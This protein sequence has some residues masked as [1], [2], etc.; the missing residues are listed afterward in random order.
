MAPRLTGQ[1]AQPS[2]VT[3]RPKFNPSASW[4]YG[5]QA[6]NAWNQTNPGKPKI[7][8]AWDQSWLTAWNKANPSKTPLTAGTNPSKPATTP[9]AP[10]APT[11]AANKQPVDPTY[12]ADIAGLDQG[13]WNTHVD[14]NASRTNT[15]L[16]Y[17]YNETS[18]GQ[19][20]VDPNNP[21]SRAA[22]LAK[23][24]R[25][26]KSGTTNSLAS[27]GQLYSGALRNAQ[28]VNDS[29]NLQQTDSMQKALLRFLAD[30]T[31]Q[32]S[33]ADSEYWTGRGG[34]YGRMVGRNPTNPLYAPTGETADPA[35]QTNAAQGATTPQSQAWLDAWRKANPGKALPDPNSPT[36]KAMT[37]RRGKGYWGKL[38]PEWIAAWMKANPGKSLPGGN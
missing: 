22:L 8:T 6:V 3:K 24:Y 4:S 15:L 18:P 19:V 33:R 25:E 34:A 26:A 9:A 29:Q 36:Q 30:N 12:N 14:L 31:K 28:D 38:T 32:G 23:S 1:Y 37:K 35:T 20:T 21:Y 10:T 16:D 2:T 27:Q 17:G 5:Q 11:P 7:S 13:L